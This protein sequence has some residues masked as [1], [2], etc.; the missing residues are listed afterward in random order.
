MV[1]SFPS[2]PFDRP[3]AVQ[4]SCTAADR[5]AAAMDAPQ[6]NTEEHRGTTEV[7]ERAAGAWRT[8]SRLPPEDRWGHRLVHEDPPRVRPRRY[9][10]AHS[11]GCLCDPGQR[12]TGSPCGRAGP[13]AS[14]ARALG[15]SAPWSTVS[16]RRRST[17]RVRCRPRARRPTAV[18]PRWMHHRGTR[19]NTEEP[20]RSGRRRLRLGE[21]GRSS[22]WKT[23]GVIGSF[24]K[25]RLVCDPVAT[26]EPI[27]RAAC[28]IRPASHRIAVR[29][30]G[31]G[32]EPREGGRR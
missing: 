3:G 5:S 13:E 27:R 7:G 18:R 23:D 24:T 2:P 1:D 30:S 4:A 17:D 8:R 20:Q 21:P 19:R 15:G 22:L 16:R 14:R 9:R 31:P 12:R 26:V 28:V 6:R 11:T 32:S 25:T 29:K 10:R